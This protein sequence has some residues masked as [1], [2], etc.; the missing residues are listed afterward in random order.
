MDKSKLQLIY[1]LDCYCYWHL[2]VETQYTLNLKSSVIIPYQFICSILMNVILESTHVCAFFS[3]SCW[4]TLSRSCISFRYIG[5]LLLDQ[6]LFLSDWVMV[7]FNFNYGP[8]DDEGCWGKVLGEIGSCLCLIS[9][10][11]LVIPGEGCFLSS[12]RGGAA[13]A[14]RQSSGRFGDSK[15]SAL[16]C[17]PNVLISCLRVLLLSQCSCLI[18][19]HVKVTYWFSVA[20]PKSL[21]S[22]PL[23]DP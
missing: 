22:S 9:Q 21:H 3:N 19:R 14:G 16:S 17:L 6:A 12:R 1:L 5:Y 18:M 13:S 10:L 2:P 4:F 7:G 23:V 20:P 15:F 11:L 8:G